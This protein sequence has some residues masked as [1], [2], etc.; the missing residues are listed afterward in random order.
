MEQRICHTVWQ[1]SKMSLMRLFSECMLDTGPDIIEDALLRCGGRVQTVGLEQVTVVG[2]AIEQER[3]RREFELLCQLGIHVAEFPGI[4]EPI[5]RRDLDAGENHVGIGLADYAYDACQIG[6]GFAQRKPAQAIVDA[7]FKQQQV[8]LV[9]GKIG[10]D[11][12]QAAARGFA[13]DAGID[14]R[15]RRNTC[16]LY[17]S[18]SP[19]D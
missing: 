4:I 8:G 15:G 7:E 2:D 12:R 3:H 9:R 18:P 13:A 10:A 6:A 16:L 11:A 17:T 5:I 1:F 14:E 19:R